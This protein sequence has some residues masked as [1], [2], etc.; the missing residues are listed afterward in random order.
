[1]WRLSSAGGEHKNPNWRD[2]GAVHLSP[3]GGG[4]SAAADLGVEFGDG[5]QSL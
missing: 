4:E 2:S 3:A 5:L 1:M